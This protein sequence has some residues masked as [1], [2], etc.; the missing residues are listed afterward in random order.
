MLLKQT[1]ILFRSNTDKV[2]A[3]SLFCDHC[4]SCVL[5]FV[6]ILNLLYSNL[7]GE[8]NYFAFYV[9]Y[10]IF[11][12]L[13]GLMAERYLLQP[14]AEKWISPFHGKKKQSLILGK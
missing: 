12:S 14:V 1:C 7:A 9:P 11:I 13:S 10:V 2:L 5:F 4:Y 8:F 6:L 3:A